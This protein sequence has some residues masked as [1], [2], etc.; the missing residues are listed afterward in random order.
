[1]YRYNSNFYKFTA[2]FFVF[3]LLFSLTGCGDKKEGINAASYDNP[4][5]YKEADKKEDSELMLE[6]AYYNNPEWY[7]DAIVLEWDTDWDRMLT[8]ED[9]VS[10]E[11][12]TQW[13]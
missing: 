13:A 3:V 12:L 10:K 5:W 4:E 1:M 6:D 11:A 2:M 7:K 9:C 8:P